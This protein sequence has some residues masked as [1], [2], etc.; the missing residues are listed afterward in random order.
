MTPIA[1]GEANVVAGFSPCSNNADCVV[2][3]ASARDY[4][5]SVIRNFVIGTL[6]YLVTAAFVFPQAT[7]EIS[8]RVT[9][10]SGAVLPGSAVTLTQTETG[11]ARTTISGE[12]GTYTFPSL[13]VGSY[14]LEIALPGF[15]TFVSTIALQVGANMSVD[16]VMQVGDIAQT[17]EVQARSEIEVETRRMGVA[18]VIENQRILELPLAARE[19]TSLITLS[20]AAVQ[21]GTS[22]S[23]NMATG[24]NISVAGGQRFGVSYLLDGAGHTNRF[25]QTNLPTPF[26]DALAE[27][28]V[29]MSSQE[30]GTGRASGASVNQVT[31]SGTNDYHGDA[32][33]FLRN[34]W[35]NAI[36]A[37]AA[38]EDPL[39]RNQFGGTAGGPIVRN[40]MFFFGGYQSTILREFPTETLSIVPTE[41]MLKG[42][43]SRFNA[44]YHP[45]WNN[46]L[47]ADF[48]DGVLNPSTFSTAAM[49]LAARLPKPQNDCG[50]IRWGVRNER[51]DKQIVGRVDYQRTANHSV[52]GRYIGTLQD[53]KIPYELDSSNLLTSTANGFDDTTQSAA[54]GS[55]WVI[56]P[57]MINS[58]RFSYARVAVN[59]G[60]ATF[61]NPSDVGIESY[62]TVPQH[63]N[64]GVSG[65]FTLGS[66][67]TAKRAM[68]QNQYEVSDDL[69]L[70]RGTHQLAF[71][72]NWGRADIQSRSHTRGVGNL[73]ITSLNS[74]NAM[75]DFF[76]GRLDN[77][78]QSMPSILNQYQHY[79]GGY[80]QDTWRITPRLTF[81]YG[82]RWEPFLP[83]VWTDA[84][85]YE[86]FNLGGIRVYNFSLEG[87]KAGR[88]SNVFPNAPAG[89][90]YP[91]QGS[92]AA[93]FDGASAIKKGWEKFAPRVGLAWDPTGKGRTAVR[94]G[95]GISYDVVPLQSLL[96]TNNVSPWA[97]DVVHRNGTLENPWLGFTPGNPFPF[98]WQLNPLFTEG[99]IYMPFDAS[100]DTAY[101]QSWN[102]EIQ[103]EIAGTWRASVGYLGS[104]SAD[105][106]ITEA[107]NP[108]V[109]LTPQSQP[110]LFTGPDTCVLEGRAYTPCNQTGNINQRR[111][112]RLWAVASGDPARLAD[113]KLIANIDEYRSVSTANYN[114]LLTSIRG[115]WRELN[116]NA[117][118][119][120]SHCLSDRTQD[121]VGNPNQTPHRNRDRSNCAADRRHM[122]NLTAV[123]T[124]PRFASR[125]LRAVASDWRLSI[126]YRHSSAAN[127]TVTTTDWARTGLTGQVVNQVLPDIYQD[128]SGDLGTQLYNK[129]AFTNPVP[130]TYGN[131]NFNTVLGFRRWDFDAALSRI[132]AAGE[133]QRFEVRAEA[134]NVTNSVRPVDP[135]PSFND[136]NFGRV[137]NVRDPRIMQ[138]ALKYVF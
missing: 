4:M 91:S 112:L 66:P 65:H 5:R 13:P 63:F 79:I 36:Q 14:R 45:A 107:V 136:I 25:D 64:F 123:A 118:Y 11:L 34:A 101:T 22:P 41:A 51:H 2:M 116:V 3:R 38:K 100:L 24:V 95:F 68:W 86:G 109:I 122:L 55:T 61:F 48:Q 28:R 105:L 76:L 78:R 71:G 108:A 133:N 69:A 89:F 94:A 16:A 88:K 131:M 27:F 7:G 96:N 90:T 18:T 97:T 56:S 132:F 128:R 32:F 74:G 125:S 138:F 49:R 93:D 121:N 73:S 126:V 62:T 52:F 87:F 30:A 1:I 17:I 60:G 119:T 12:V 84:G 26:P 83:M 10:A 58:S 82:L 114:G 113:A 59:K 70:T 29:A 47:G 57:T 15:R 20:G 134:F 6:I 37:T 72:A 103:Q 137:R 54:V 21:V 46:A 98:D 75:G 92:G 35:F 19:V 81:N 23:W 120:W 44:C 53:Q 111:E 127:Y 102:L 115:D 135:S 106:W 117:N 9:D 85:R 130:G 104:Q 50:E 67:T 8:G 43:W 99:S 110:S 33:W 39:K 129:A 77:I 31:K 40:R 42:D 124:A 80:G